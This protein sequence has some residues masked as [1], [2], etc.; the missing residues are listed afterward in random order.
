M[1]PR[2][3]T[4][5]AGCAWSMYELGLDAEAEARPDQAETYYRAALILDPGMADAHCNLGVLLHG[6]GR[7]DAA[8]PHY[9]AALEIGGDPARYHYNLAV[10]REDQGGLDDAIDHYRAAIAVD[11]DMS[12]AHY[13]L[14]QCL[15]R[16]KRTL[17]DEQA[18]I[19]H[20]NAYRKITGH[21][22]KR[23]P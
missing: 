5:R 4:L 13:N 3:P 15:A 21:R 19:R 8:E 14:G 1:T 17:A 2:K 12:D 6:L 18:A 16:R 9:R 7:T 23:L 22:A 10:L 20:L 11:P